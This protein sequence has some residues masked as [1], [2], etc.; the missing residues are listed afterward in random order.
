MGRASYFLHFILFESVRLSMKF[1]NKIVKVN[2]IFSLGRSSSKLAE[3]ILTGLTWCLQNGVNHI[4]IECDSLLVINMVRGRSKPPCNML[5]T[6]NHIQGTR[7]L[8]TCSVQH[9]YRE[10]NHVADALAK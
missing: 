5:D 10:V 6:I 7:R 1:K 8:L 2:M 9:Y 3:A 4:I